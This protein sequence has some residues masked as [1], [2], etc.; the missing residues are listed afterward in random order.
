MQPLSVVVGIANGL[1]A[2]KMEVRA[3]LGFRS[4][5]QILMALPGPERL[6]VICV[7][8]TNPAKRK[9]P[10]TDQRADKR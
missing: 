7:M 3:A 5:P 2:A 4:Q 9:K 1:L 6:A 10:T 8:A